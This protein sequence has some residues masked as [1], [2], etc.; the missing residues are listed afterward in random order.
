MQKSISGGLAFGF[1][2]VVFLFPLFAQLLEKSV[3][4]KADCFQGAVMSPEG[5]VWMSRD[6]FGK[7]NSCSTVCLGIRYKCVWVGG[8]GLLVAASV[9]S[10]LQDE[11]PPA[12]LQLQALSS[13]C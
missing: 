1:G 4:E 8:L 9:L 13:G 10:R 5:E 2:P 6:G 12:P 3:V 11:W 7:G